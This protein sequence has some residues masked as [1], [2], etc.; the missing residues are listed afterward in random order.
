MS[1]R[2]PRHHSFAGTT[3]ISGIGATEFSKDSGRSELRLATEAVRSALDDAGIAP[4]EEPWNEDE[5]S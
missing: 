5:V 1:A 2:S 3:A 4:S